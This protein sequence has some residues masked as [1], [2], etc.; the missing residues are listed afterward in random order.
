MPKCHYGP[1]V[2]VGAYGGQGISEISAQAHLHWG[3]VCTQTNPMLIYTVLEYKIK[4]DI[5]S[6]WQT[7]QQ[8]GRVR[9]ILVRM[10]K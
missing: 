8:T 3:G 4:I 6:N 5:F 10:A 2:I 1:S 9:V 7:P